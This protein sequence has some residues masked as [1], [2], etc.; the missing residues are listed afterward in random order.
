MFRSL[1]ILLFH[2]LNQCTFSVRGE[3]SGFPLDSLLAALGLSGGIETGR[4]GLGLLD[5]LLRNTTLESVKSQH[6]VRIFKPPHHNTCS[7]ATSINQCMCAF[8]LPL[9][10]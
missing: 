9:F 1:P 10:N 7:Y 3:I 4:K 8:S 6:T 2:S 5:P